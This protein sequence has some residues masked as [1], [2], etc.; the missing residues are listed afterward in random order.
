MAQARNKKYTNKK[1]REKRNWKE[2]KA[3]A[4]RFVGINDFFIYYS[5]KQ[6]YDTA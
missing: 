1:G 3:K 2:E 6:H 4:N 5:S